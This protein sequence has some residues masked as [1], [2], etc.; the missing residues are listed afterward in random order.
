M[1]ILTLPFALTLAVA[2]SVPDTPDTNALYAEILKT[3]VKDGRVD[4]AA[5]ESKDLDKLDRYLEGVASA[6]L[7]TDR[8]R[9]IAFY[10][11]AYNALV[12]RSVIKHK[13]PR[14]VLDVKDF[15]K[16]RTHK[17]AGQ[18]VSLDELEKK[19]LSPYA[20]DPRTHFVLVCAAVGCPILESKPYLGDD[21]D[22][23]FDVAT[24]R[25]LSSPAGARVKPG[26]IALSKIFD[27]YANDFG[28]PDGARD[29]ALR[30]LRTADRKA[31]GDSPRVTFLDYNWT[32]N[33][34]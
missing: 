12:L 34:Q 11:D 26:Q 2:G 17:V 31:T 8:N 7:P 4:Y 5:L 23:R 29:F 14:S 27:W 28:G 6:V 3:H 32:L 30:H 21:M 10:V 22:R 24:R 25:Y 15:F 13:R 33:Q 18:M 9:R 20:R 1:T 19:V 16:M